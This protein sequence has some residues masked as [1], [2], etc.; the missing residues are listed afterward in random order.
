MIPIKRETTDVLIIGSGGAGLRAAIEA[1]RYGVRVTVIDK[2]VLG[3]NNS[4]RYSGGGIKAA[5]PGILST[6][7]TTQFECPREHFRQALIHGEYLNDETLVEVMTYEGPARVLELKSLGVDTFDAMYLKVH[8]PHGTG[9]TGPLLQT[10]RKLGCRLRPGLVITRIL[11]HGGRVVGAAGID[12]HSKRLTIF[13]TGAVILATGGGAEAY[14]RND[15]TVNTTGDGYQLA[16]D[17]GALL[18][19]ME[20]VQFEPYVQAEP[21][22]PMMDR[23]EAE[24]EFYGIL[25]NGLGEDFLGRYLPPKRQTLAS[26]EEQFGIALTDIRERVARAMAM[27]VAAGRGDNGAVLFDLTHVPD[28]KWEAD[29]ASQ[30]TRQVLLRGHDVRT[31][32]VHVMPGAICTLGGVV[33]D[34]DCRTTVAGLFAAGEAAGGVH[35]AARLGGDGLLDPIVFGARA[36]RAAALSVAETPAVP[37]PLVQDVVAEL[38]ASFGDGPADLESLAAL[39]EQVKDVMWEQVGLLRDGDGLTRAVATLTEVAERLAAAKVKTLRQFKAKREA[40]H[41][42]RN[43]QLIAAAALRRTE[44]RGAHYR[45]DHPY[46]DDRRWMVNQFVSRDRELHFSERPIRLRTLQPLADSKFGIE[47]KR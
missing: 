10:A 14:R 42:A 40:L 15:T 20:I 46:R 7:Y 41:L 6:A 13:E 36:G 31:R 28:D 26:F 29:Y 47:V 27:E 11:V 12:L 5:L 3:M 39:R 1:R 2:V 33:I 38:A 17:A 35:G 44:S 45:T 9:L 18:R 25:R 4:T 16:L 24:A 30:Y 32:P 34:E 22:L 23:H 19:D 21:N 8:Y 37:D 43:G